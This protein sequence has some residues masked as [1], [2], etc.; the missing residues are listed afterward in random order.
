MRV[1]RL[2]YNRLG[3]RTRRICWGFV[4]HGRRRREGE[5]CSR[6]G[7]QARCILAANLAA[8]FGKNQ[9]RKVNFINSLRIRLASQARLL[10][11]YR[12][13]FPSSSIQLER[14]DPLNR[15]RLSLE[16][17]LQR[18]RGY[19]TCVAGHMKEHS[20]PQLCKVTVL[21][22]CWMVQGICSAAHDYRCSSDKRNDGASIAAALPLQQ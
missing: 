18:V 9:Y 10:P 19:D 17:H 6:N 4:C 5:N 20:T 8:F 12:D 14:G 13:Y 1:E 2:N 22:C 11:G 16:G 7:R 3:K 15:I 21:F